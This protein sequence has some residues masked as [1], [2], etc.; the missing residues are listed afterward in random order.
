[1]FKI[2]EHVIYNK[3]VCKIVDIK[4][5]NSNDNDYYILIPVFDESLKIKVPAIN[6]NNRLRTISTKKEID[7][8]INQI[9][10]IEII[11]SDKPLPD[12]DYKVL[13]NSQN[14]LDIVRIVK[15]EYLNSQSENKKKVSNRDNKYLALA[16][17]YLYQELAVVLEMNIEEA[18]KYFIK[19]LDKIAQK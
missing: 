6:K 17:K 1:M 18:K 7:D 13:L 19:H 15:T 4:H 5:N 16:E 3:D 10:N 14:I 12:N 2:G 11:V 8:I 9:S